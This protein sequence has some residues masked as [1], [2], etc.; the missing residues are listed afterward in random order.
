MDPRNEVPADAAAPWPVNWSAVW[1]GALAALAALVVFGLSGAALGFHLNANDARVTNW[2]QTRDWGPIICSVL[3]AFFAF[4][5]GGWVAGKIG[6]FRFSEPAMLHAAIAWL[7]ALPLIVL[8]LSAGGAAYLDTWYGAL[9]PAV[10]SSDNPE[11]AAA[12]R[13]AALT[14]ITALLLGL[15]GS[16]IGGWMASG[17][18][19]TFNHHL[20]RT[21]R[22]ASASAA[23]QQ[24]LTV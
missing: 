4:V 13:N 11:V 5:I 12:V 6:G 3:S 20:R 21:N 19:M 1:V 14:A 2:H 16:V 7:V 22:W 24:R 17:E 18:L 10:A 15:V 23:P 8:A 9:H